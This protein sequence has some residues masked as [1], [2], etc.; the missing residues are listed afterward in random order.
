LDTA[1]VR[2]LFVD[3][4]SIGRSPRKRNVYTQ[5][6]NKFT[7]LQVGCIPDFGFRISDFRGQFFREALIKSSIKIGAHFCPPWMASRKSKARSAL[8]SFVQQNASLKIRMDADF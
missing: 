7:L 2:N 5:Y 4:F 1:V 6:T 3:R 8:D